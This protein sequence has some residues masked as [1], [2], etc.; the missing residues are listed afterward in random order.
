MF[1]EAW[2]K[3]VCESWNS[4]H[5]ER[6]S[7][8][9]YKRKRRYLEQND[10]YDA[11]S[12]KGCYSNNAILGPESWWV[13]WLALTLD[14]RQR[15]LHNFPNCQKYYNFKSKVSR[16]YF[17]NIFCFMLFVLNCIIFSYIK[18]NNFRFKL[19]LWFEK[20]YYLIR[21]DAEYKIHMHFPNNIT[22][23]FKKQ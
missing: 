17:M 5:G 22:Y 8:N 4:L 20:K 2:W 10:N 9:K 21:Y 18:R 16:R 6:V 7:R 14:L 11:C 1:A 3:V 23:W 12:W 15:D 13:C 19:V